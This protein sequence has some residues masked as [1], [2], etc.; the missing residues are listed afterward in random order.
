MKI[1]VTN[2]DG[3][4]A[5]GMWVLAKELRKVAEVIV[6]AP[7]REQSG[8]GTS[9][10]LHHPLRVWE[11]P[12]MEPGIPA[13]CLDGTPADA[14]IVGL[15]TLVEE[16]GIGL[17]VSG[18]NEGSNLGNDV[19]ISGTVGAALQG[20]FR[21]IPSVAVSVAAVENVI[22]DVAAQLARLLVHH[23]IANTLPKAILLNVNVPNAPLKEIKGV[24]I[25][26]LARRTFVELIKEGHDGRRKYYWIDRGKPNMDFEEGTDMWAIANHR[27]SVT[28]LH[29]DLTNNATMPAL[30]GLGVGLLQG[31]KDRSQEGDA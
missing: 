6:V 14:V 27:I 26:H 8:V 22:F 5:P 11:M 3:I 7:D 31:L 20:Y 2:D 4:Y 10:T 15:G 18:I 28:P 19:L 25:T 1:L 24:E 21:G 30:E 17:V 12:L 16:N 23:F 9:L 13:Y 29:A